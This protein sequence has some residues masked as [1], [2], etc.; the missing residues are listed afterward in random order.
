MYNLHTQV[1]SNPA[2]FR[3]L[4]C[5]ESLITVYDCPLENNLQDLWS[6]HSYIVYVIEGRKIWHT[7]DGSF[8]LKKGSCVLV[9]KGACI[10]EQFF[11]VKFCLVVF[12]IP[13]KFICEVLKSKT[14]PVI[15]PDKKYQTILTIENDES[16]QS[17]F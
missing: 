8:D 1:V 14:K 13:D 2:H 4:S 7:T 9:R 12:F 10:V 16:V 17:F 3:Q 6:H 5:G 15:Q 11:D